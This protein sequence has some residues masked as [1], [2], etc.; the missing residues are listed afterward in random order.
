M[1]ADVRRALVRADRAYRVDSARSPSRGTGTIPPAPT[2]D[3]GPICAGS[4]PPAIARPVTLPSP[5]DRRRARGNPWRRRRCVHAGPAGRDGANPED[6]SHLD[7]PKFPRLR[8]ERTCDPVAPETSDRDRH[9]RTDTRRAQFASPGRRTTAGSGLSPLPR[10]FR[11][12]PRL[13]RSF[14]PHRHRLRAQGRRRD[15]ALHRRPLADRHRVL[16]DHEGA[17]ARRRSSRR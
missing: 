2:A 17:R 1:R 8:A 9:W 16:A 14:A 4:H 3:A 5:C 12:H 7:A 10:D 15:R 6:A 13:H 11:G